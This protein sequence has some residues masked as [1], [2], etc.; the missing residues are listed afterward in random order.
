MS[1]GK[2]LD[3]RT[4]LR[5][6]GVAIA[7]PLFDAM[8]PAMARASEKRRPTRVAFCYAPNGI[9]MDHWMPGGR[10]GGLSELKAGDLPLPAELPRVSRMFLPFRNEILMIDSLASEGQRSRGEGPGG[11]ARAMSSYLTATRPK[12]T[13]GK[14]LRAGVSVDQMLAA[15]AGR[16]TRLASLELSCEEGLQ[17]GS[18]DVGFSCAYTN[19]L[20]WRTPSAPVPA[21]VRP[22]AV[23]ER[24]FGER[25]PEND[26]RLRAAA[27]EMR[28]SILD[29][30]LSSAKE[31]MGALGPGDRRKLDEYL[32]ALRDIEK[33]IERT[34]KE[35][36]AK[37]PFGPPAAAVPENFE[38]H[39]RLM[40]DLLV[41]AFQTDSTRVATWVLGV[42]SSMRTYREIGVPEAHHGL[43]HHRGDPEKIEKVTRINELHARSAAYL[44]K[45]LKGTPD[46]DGSLLDHSMIVF[47]SGL[48]DG[49]KHS[50]ERLP[51]ILAGRGNGTL[52]PGRLIRY[53]GETPIAN[54]WVSILERM[55]VREARVGDSQG[56]L[57]GLG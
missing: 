44:L 24:L 45:R 3:R 14:D 43:S 1:F 48:S 6:L 17:G 25:D 53:A 41:A 55:G 11:H 27:R 31:L 19:N 40:A 34:E 13:L 29:A 4:F 2:R 56:P 26:P 21:E 46:G 39:A 35:G 15:E 50:P 57:S 42:E 20:S 5:G 54:L 30:S 12:R 37:A 52:R 7:L 33:R 8:V 36:F 16:K 32:T 51:T 22:R 28:A 23:F 9:I 38:E 47:G 18:C 10:S 49:D